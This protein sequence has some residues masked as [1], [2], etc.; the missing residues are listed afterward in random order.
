MRRA[1]VVAITEQWHVATSLAS[2]GELRYPVVDKMS[3]RTFR[4]WQCS[5]L[6]G[7]RVSE[8]GEEGGSAW[9]LCWTGQRENKG[10]GILAW[11]TT[12]RGKGRSGG[13]VARHALEQE[14]RSGG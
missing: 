9:W 10:M 11:H 8:V 2:P 1:K 3:P 5:V 6:C 4:R 13:P 12:W 7:S 14:G